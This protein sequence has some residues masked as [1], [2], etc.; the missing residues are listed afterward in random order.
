[1]ESCKHAAAKMRV[2]HNFANSNG[3][4]AIGEAV[5]YSLL[6]ELGDVTNVSTDRTY[7]KK[8]IDFLLDGVGYDTK[9]DTRAASTGN[10]AIETISRRQNGVVKAK[11]WALTSHA[12]CVVYMYLKGLDWNIMLLTKETIADILTKGYPV[13]SAKNYSYE[14]EVVLAPIKD[15]GV[16]MLVPVAGEYDISTLKEFHES[17][18]TS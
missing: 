17:L 5:F 7:Q 18:K 3:I 1:M 10:I 8:G 14:S 9:L 11:G 12:D 6:S 15:L 4:G 13:R 16:D 2:I